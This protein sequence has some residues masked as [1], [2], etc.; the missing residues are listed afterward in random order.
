[1]RYLGAG[2]SCQPH[3]IHQDR[4]YDLDLPVM[5]F[6]FSD[7]PRSVICSWYSVVIVLGGGRAE[8]IES[9]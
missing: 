3:S 8:G 4:L 5:G 6:L 9:S 1:M 2:Q 7:L